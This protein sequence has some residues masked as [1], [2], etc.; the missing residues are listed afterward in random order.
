M[1]AVTNFLR[2][3]GS[4]RRQLTFLSN[5][6]PVR[7]MIENQY[8]EPFLGGGAVFFYVNPKS[9][10]LSDINLE[11]IELYRG[12]RRDPNGVW[13]HY[14]GFGHNKNEYHR[15]RDE[16]KGGDLSLRAA[17][18]LYLNRTCFKGMWRYNSQGKFNVGYGGEERRW[19]INLDNLKEVSAV[20]QQADIQCEDFG[21]IIQKSGKGDFI[22][23]D[24]PYRPGEFEQKNDHYAWK[25]FTY[26]DNKRLAQALSSASKRGVQWALSISSHLKI[27]DLY[28][29]NWAVEFPMVTGRRPGIMT[30]QS[31]EVLIMNY[32][33]E[34]TIQL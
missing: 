29:D 4:K 11:L 30:R 16:V 26:E 23:V 27:L 32:E 12:I 10:I 8:I 22:F 33:N 24:P 14:S 2:Y 3:P 6:L 31:G 13:N 21:T 5:Y 7:D 1:E 18:I 28:K 34:G 19:V 9:A 15:I 25:T 17:R 20:L